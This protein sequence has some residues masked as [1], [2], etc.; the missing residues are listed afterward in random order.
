MRIMRER[1]GENLAVRVV[2]L[3]PAEL[4]EQVDEV[5]HAERLQNRSAAVRFMIE[6]YLAG[7]EKPAATKPARRR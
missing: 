1:L 6:A 4:I 7:R 2:V 3:M 5:W